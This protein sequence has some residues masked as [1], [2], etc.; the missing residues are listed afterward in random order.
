MMVRTPAA[1]ALALGRL[2]RV[3]VAVVATMVAAAAPSSA[4]RASAGVDVD[5][6]VYGGTPGGAVAAIAAKRVLGARGV[7]ALVEGGHHIGGMLAAG[8]IDDSIRGDTQAYA[9]L[10]AE[11][12]RRT[13]LAYKVCA[14]SAPTTQ[15]A[16]TRTP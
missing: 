13:A 12:Y 16:H 5:V 3:V 4:A 2:A 14:P 7:V 1:T 15:P 8:M 6:L 9:G 11:L 10:A